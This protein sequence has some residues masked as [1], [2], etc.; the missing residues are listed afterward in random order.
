MLDSSLMESDEVF[1]VLLG[2]LVPSLEGGLTLVLAVPSTLLFT[3]GLV[4]AC[5]LYV[6]RQNT[7][8]VLIIVYRS[9][10]GETVFLLTIENMVAARV[11]PPVLHLGHVPSRLGRWS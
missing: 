6:C 4:S 8:S 5:L 9:F 2:S 1:D 11:R 7:S 10:L 3:F